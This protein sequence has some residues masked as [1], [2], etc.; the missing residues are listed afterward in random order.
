MKLDIY[1]VYVC[2]YINPDGCEYK[3]TIAEVDKVLGFTPVVIIR[4][5]TD[6]TFI[7]TKVFKNGIPSVKFD[8]RYKES[9]NNKEIDMTG[10]DDEF[11]IEVRSAVLMTV[12]TGFFYDGEYLQGLLKV[13]YGNSIAKEITY[14]FPP[15]CVWRV[16]SLGSSIASAWSFKLL[17]CAG[18]G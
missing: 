11:R 17:R 4:K 5:S 9:P 1:N 15:G 3:D 6:Q 14:T 12:S 7:P 16:H 10:Y 18:T 2:N 13:T 8:V